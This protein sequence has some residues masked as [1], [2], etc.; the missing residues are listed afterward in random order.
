MKKVSE[1]AKQEPMT[2]GTAV[3]SV[4][5]MYENYDRTGHFAAIDL[6]RVLGDPCEGVEVLP[7][8]EILM[9][10]KSSSTK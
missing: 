9:A 6:R 1:M 7:S 4:R 10:S 5:Q 3:S 2:S 8:C